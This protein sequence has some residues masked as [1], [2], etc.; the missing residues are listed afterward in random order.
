MIT[1][2]DQVAMNQEAVDQIQAECEMVSHLPKLPD[3]RLERAYSGIDSP[4]AKMMLLALSDVKHAK[5]IS[6]AKRK[7]PNKDRTQKREQALRVELEAQE[8]A[9]REKRVRDYSNGCPLNLTDEVRIEAA[10]DAFAGFL[11]LLAY[12]PDVP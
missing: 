3:L 8:K 1:L 6:F 5:A 2:Y 11:E 10:H 9:E 12:A 7:E 4:A